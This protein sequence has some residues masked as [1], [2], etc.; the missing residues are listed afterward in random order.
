MTTEEVIAWAKAQIKLVQNGEGP[1]RH[2]FPED[3]Q[4][5]MSR[6][7]WHLPMFSYGMEFGYLHGMAELI[8]HL[9]G[10]SADRQGTD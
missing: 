3:M 5:E 9:E 1:S 6:L 7:Y 8:K 2:N 10:G 4:A